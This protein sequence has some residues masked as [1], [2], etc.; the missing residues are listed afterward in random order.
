M[1]AGRLAPGAATS[2]T[3]TS[4]AVRAASCERPGASLRLR[5]IPRRLPWLRSLVNQTRD[6]S[7]RTVH[8]SPQ[9]PLLA[10]GTVPSRPVRSRHNRLRANVRRAGSTVDLTVASNVRSTAPLTVLLV[11]VVDVTHNLR[12]APTTNDP[13]RLDAPQRSPVRWTSPTRAGPNVWRPAAGPRAGRTRQRRPET[14]TTPAGC[15]TLTSCVR[16]RPTHRCSRRRHLRGC[17]LNQCR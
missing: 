15:P 4:R 13:G 1:L 2:T 5:T 17:L 7:A 14:W 3:T 9:R 12:S 10:G 8:R 11:L 16:A 6:V